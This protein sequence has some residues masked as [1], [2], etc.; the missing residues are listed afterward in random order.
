MTRS[1]P[2][3]GAVAGVG[4][5]KLAGVVVAVLLLSLVGAF[6]L[7]VLGVPSVEGVENR[8]GEVT[9]ETTVIH[10]DLLVHNP[11]PVG[12]QLG[13]TSVNYTV[14][15]NE[16]EMAA[17]G[18]AGLD[19]ARGNSTQAF[20]TEME[21]AQIPPWWVSHIDAGEHTR[22][23]IDA[24][25]RTSL[26]GEREFDLEQ[27]EEVQ[28][29]LIGEF[30]SEETRP[31]HADDPPPL[32]DNPVLYVNETR[33]GWGAVTEEV[34]PIDMTFVLYNPQTVPYTVSELGYEI[35]MNDV[36]VGEGRT[37]DV[38]V[39]PP[40]GTETVRTTTEIRNGELDTWW[41][42]H[43]Q[44]DQV[45]DL[46]IEFYAVLSGDELASDV[47]VPMDELTYEETIET[48]IFG[49]KDE[50]RDGEGDGKRDGDEPTPTPDATT[51]TPTPTTTPGDTPSP[52]PTPT[53]TPTP[54]PTPTPE[55]DD[56]IGLPAM[57]T[58]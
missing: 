23:S 25:V 4:K 6:V 16:V 42:T 3:I 40:G 1:I 18:G 43:L 34:T 20:E 29:D 2:G 48:D 39:I 11:N 19:L 30:T 44:N 36:P 22:V 9:D 45:T 27:E 58:R 31:V 54:T 50:P 14:E 17:G 55:E 5:L 53:A 15:M 49:T 35:T 12:V 46:R 21:N 32:V 56:G 57:P 33:A 37:E 26:L 28:T 24:T 51:E 41:V 38:A 10:T 13:G 52:T 8:F 7:G 47:R